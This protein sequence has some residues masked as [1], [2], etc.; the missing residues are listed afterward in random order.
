MISEIFRTGVLKKIFAW[1][2]LDIKSWI[3]F[4]AILIFIAISD[5]QSIKG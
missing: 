5:M 1:V 3:K 2:F 4:G